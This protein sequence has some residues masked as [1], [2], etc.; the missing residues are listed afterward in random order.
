MNLETLFKTLTT[1]RVGE[2][3][4][5]LHVFILIMLVTLAVRPRVPVEIS[6]P[7]DEKGMPVTT[8]N[9]ESRI[10][11]LNEINRVERQKLAERLDAIDE[12]N[13]R[14]RAR[15]AEANRNE[16]DEIMEAVLNAAQKTANE[17]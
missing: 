2:W 6:W 13:R 14:E 1:G 5:I 11:E 12:I 3:M 9:V 17:D 10:D 16:R 8:A 7:V 4:V 15:I